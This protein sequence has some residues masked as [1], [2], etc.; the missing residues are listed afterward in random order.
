MSM[1]KQ[2]LDNE[3]TLYFIFADNY[4]LTKVSQNDEKYTLTSKDIFQKCLDHHCAKDWFYSPEYNYAAMFLEEDTPNLKDT[5]RVPIRSIFYKNKDEAPYVAHALAILNWR[6][7]TR[8]CSTCGTPL[9]DHK[10]ETAKYCIQCKKNIYPQ[11]SPCIIV[12]ITKGDKILLARHT[13]RNTDVYTCLAGY[14]EPGETLEECVEREV[15]EETG[16]KI[17]NIKYEKS[18]SWPF[19]DQLM[20][21]FSAEYEYGEPKLQ[22]EEIQEVFWFSKDNLPAI[23]KPGSLAFE[24][25]TQ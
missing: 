21:G 25:I 4:I 1:T 20:I 15:F 5:K 22:P 13:Q 12:R 8:F 6:N 16:I 17:K 18:Q 10:T 24:L 3:E 7:Q 9:T 23:P 11:I 2:L 19:P 14:V